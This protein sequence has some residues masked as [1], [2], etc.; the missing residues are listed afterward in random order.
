[1]TTDTVTPIIEVENL[2]V[3]FWVGGE[4]ITAVHDVSYR[5]DPSEVSGARTP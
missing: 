4:W 2:A 3:D 1:M 5:V